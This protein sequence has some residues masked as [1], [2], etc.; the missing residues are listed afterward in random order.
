MLE[1]LLT[2]IVLLTVTVTQGNVK[3]AGT[4]RKA[5]TP[6]PLTAAGKLEHALVAQTI[7]EI[8]APRLTGEVTDGF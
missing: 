2:N 8:M 1:L 7:E 3:A 6:N 5:G 4:H